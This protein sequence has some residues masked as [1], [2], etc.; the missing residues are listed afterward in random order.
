MSFLAIDCGNTRLKW[1]LFDRPHPGARR[2]QQGAVFVEAIDN[3][4]EGDWRTLPAPGSMLGCIVAGDAVRR[5]G[6]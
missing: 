4:A 1:A 2:L 6:S 3:L 5:R